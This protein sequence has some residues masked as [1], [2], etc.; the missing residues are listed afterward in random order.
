[1]FATLCRHA[2]IKKTGILIKIDAIEF[3]F[4]QHQTGDN[5]TAIHSVRLYHLYV[6]NFG[7]IYPDWT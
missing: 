3:G 1:M 5:F 4:Y 2:H 6:M 7:Q